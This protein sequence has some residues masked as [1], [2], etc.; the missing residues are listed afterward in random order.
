MNDTVIPIK[1]ISPYDSPKLNGLS[2]SGLQSHASCQ[3]R[4][5][6]RKLNAAPRLDTIHTG[7]GKAFGEGVQAIM[8][9]KSWEQ[10]IWAAF[11]A[12]PFPV[13]MDGSKD[14]KGFFNCMRALELFS[15]LWELGYAGNYDLAMIPDPKTGELLP[16]CELGFKILLPNGYYY[17]GYVDA[18]LID[19]ST[20]QLVVLEL[21][22]TNAK[23]VKEETYKNSR[24]AL[25]YAVVLDAIA[26]ALSLDRT[27]Y[28]VLYLVF[29]TM[30]EEFVPMPFIKSYRQRAR[31]IKELVME[32]TMIAFERENKHFIRSGNC[33]GFGTVCE[34]FGMCESDLEMLVDMTKLAAE[35]PFERPVSAMFEF[36]FEQ[37][38]EAQKELIHES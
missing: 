15:Q 27:S 37:L 24:Q 31:F 3:M 29:M 26:K 18:V 23:Y 38:I 36:T 16:A 14:N 21:K 9:G 1:V 25:G 32:A 4:W 19:K 17:I 2:Y 6:L 13:D 12:W 11:L 30:N 35:V 5:A 20:G 22:T 28:T 8:S 7:Y 33:V 10:V 34:F